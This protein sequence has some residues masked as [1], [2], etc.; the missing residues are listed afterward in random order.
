MMNTNNNYYSM[1]HSLRRH[2][3]ERQARIQAEARFI[4]TARR[5]ISNAR[6]S[7]LINRAVTVS[8][9]VYTIS[10]IHW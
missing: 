5:E 9:L 6:W 8:A 10:Q 3:R 1:N 2:E 7:L 4:R